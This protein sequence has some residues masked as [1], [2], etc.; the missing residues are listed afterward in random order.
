MAAEASTRAA[1]AG[2]LRRP[3]AYDRARERATRDKFRL[4]RL[5]RFVS[6]AGARRTRWRAGS[7]AART[8]P[9]S[10]WASPGT[11]SPPA[12]PSGRGSC[13]TSSGPECGRSAQ[14][15]E[16]SDRPEGPFR[17]CARIGQTR[18]FDPRLERRRSSGEELRPSHAIASRCVSTATAS[19]DCTGR[20][21]CRGGSTTRR[22]SSSG[23]TGSTSRSAAPATRRCSSRRAR[24][25]RPGH[26]WFY[27]YYRDRALMLQLGH[28]AARDAPAARGREGRPEPPAAAR[29]RRTGAIR[30]PER[31]DAAPR[32]RARSSCRPSAA[33]RPGCTSRPG[34]SRGR[35]PPPSGRR[36]RLLLCG[37]RHHVRGRVLGE[38]QH[39]L[40]PQAAGPVPRRGQRLRD[41]GAG[42]GP[43]RRRQHLAPRALVPRTCSSARWT[44]ATR[45]PASRSCARRSAWCRARR[46]PA[47]VHARVIRPY[48]HSLSDDEAL[49]RSPAEREEDARARPARRPSPACSWQEGVATDERARAPCAS[50]VDREVDRPPPTPPSRRRCPTPRARRAT[51]TRRA[52]THARRPSPPSPRPPG[53]PKTMVDLL[54]ACLHDEMARDPRIVVFGE[55][56]ADCSREASLSGGQG[57]GRR[58]QGHP[59]PAAQVR[60]ATASSTRRSPR[61]TSSAAPSGWPRAASSRWSRSSSST[62]SGR[63]T[64]RSA[65]SWR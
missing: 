32:P 8:S 15:A 55:D 21:T 62:T 39:R 9:T 37:R 46:G 17:R 18:H 16:G 33:P 36:G 54:N 59:Q 57:Q 2:R 27:A 12:R 7:P 23:R 47:L 24:V 41:L 40:Q 50:E 13:W 10:S 38:P 45:W 5:C 63:R 22:S 53:D 19:S 11:S 48:S 43:D 64:C 65:T 60:L 14:P 4:N 52:S 58:L 30:A 6:L 3:A 56:V 25:L 44:A 29:C 51:S 20:C 28:D 42:R 35:R 31:R 1:S 49:Y 34:T 61:P 26:D